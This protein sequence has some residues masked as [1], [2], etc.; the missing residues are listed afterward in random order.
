MRRPAHTFQVRH[1]PFQI[2]PLAIAP[3]LPGETLKAALM[4]ARVVSDPVKNPMIGWWYEVYVFYVKHRDMPDSS[5]FQ[6]MVLQYGYDLTSVTA[7]AKVEHYHGGGTVDWVDQCQ[8]AVIPHYFRDDGEA[9][10]VATVG[11]LPAAKINSNSWLDSAILDSAMPGGETLA[12]GDT[13]QTT[14]LVLRQFELMRQMNLTTLTYEEFLRTFG[15]RAQLAEAPNKPELL[16]YV[17]DWKYPANTID[18]ADGSAASA[19]SWAITERLDK[20]RFFAEP[21]F[22]YSCAIARPKVYLS[23][24]VSTGASMLTDALT[25]LPAMM[26]HEPQT[27]LKKMAADAGPLAGFQGAGTEPYWVDVRDLLMYGDQ[28]CNFAMTETDAGLVALPTAAMQKKYPLSADIDALFASAAPANLV[29]TDGILSL[30]IAGS[31]VDH[32]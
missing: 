24:Q 14:D 15:V 18:P 6:N 8:R 23:K 22:I 11:N 26:S 30:Q 3:V 5:H 20:D 10:D 12:G 27:S 4:Q 32:T 21:G 19:F 1:R 2:Q 9:W 16:R 31:Q 13:A 28:F 7:A 25:W 17:R 29:R